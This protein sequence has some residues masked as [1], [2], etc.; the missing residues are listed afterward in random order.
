MRP[1]Q[2]GPFRASPKRENRYSALADYYPPLPVRP[3]LNIMVTPPRVPTINKPATMK[4]LGT[5]P[6]IEGPFQQVSSKASTS[7]TGKTLTSSDYEMKTPESFAQAVKPETPSKKEGKKPVSQEKETFEII[8]KAPIKVIALD[9]GYENFDK[10]DLIRP[11][12][13]NRNYVETSDPLKSRRYYEFILTDTG[14]VSFEHTLRDDKDPDS[15]KYSRFTIHKI[16]SPF[17]W[18]MDHLH[19]PIVLSVQFRPQTYNFKDYMDAWYNFMYLRPGSH[20]WFVKYSEQAAKSVIPRW[21]YDWWKTFGGTE[22][23]MPRSFH[24]HYERFQKEQEIST[25]PDHIKICKYYFAKRISFVIS[26]TFEIEQIERIQYL[27]KIPKIKGWVPESREIKKPKPAS[28]SGSTSSQAEL[29]KRLLEVLANIETASPVEV[30]A[31]L[32]TVSASSSTENQDNGDMEDP[33]G[34][35]Q[36]YRAYAEEE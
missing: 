25:L 14:S 36:A 12:Y 1:N 18:G 30:Q 21:F 34:I 33:H 16:M 4:V 8:S 20:T 29:K 2:K 31:M 7:Q 27:V 35:A 11:C 22:Q 28:R 24:I 3:P 9:K 5:I 26:W 13:T 10:P 15:I 19:T 6:K 32:D 23:S 17:E